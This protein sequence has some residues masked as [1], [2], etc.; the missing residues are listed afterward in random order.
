MLC[1]YTV[2]GRKLRKEY[3]TIT[4][5]HTYRKASENTNESDKP[6]N[7][8]VNLWDIQYVKRKVGLYAF[9]LSVNEMLYQSICERLLS[10]LVLMCHCLCI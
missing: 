1:M 10:V 6:S 3:K 2:G 4:H 8:V 5:K 9:N 7:G